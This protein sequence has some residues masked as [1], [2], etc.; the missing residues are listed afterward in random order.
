[1]AEIVG[2]ASADV[3][4]TFEPHFYVDLINRVYQNDLAYPIAIDDLPRGERKGAMR[5]NIRGATRRSGSISAQ[6]TI[7]GPATKTQNI[8]T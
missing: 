1:M 4:D 2:S 5:P 7:S 3:E 8:L 6:R